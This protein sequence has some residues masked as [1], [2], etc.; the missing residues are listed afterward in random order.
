MPGIS[1]M[2][3][4]GGNAV[5]GNK[6]WAPDDTDNDG[7]T[8]GNMVNFEASN[9]TIK[10]QNMTV[11]ESEA[12]LINS[13][14]LWYQKHLLSS[15]SHGVAHTTKE[16]EENENDP[17][18]WLNPLESRLPYAPNLKIYCFYGVGKPTERAYFYRD[19]T[20][21]ESQ[22]PSI[23]IDTTVTS[24]NSIIDHGV[25]M[26]EG[27]GTVNLLS[28]GYMGAK[29][30]HMKRYNPAGIKVTVYEMPHEPD[31]FSPRG[32]PNTGDHV[33]ILGR[34]SLND[35]ILRI[36][37]GQGHLIENNFVSRIKEYADR[38]KIYEE[39]EDQ[40]LLSQIK[41]IVGQMDGTSSSS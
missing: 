2:L 10:R 6:T 23:A 16:I 36:A 8:F 4:K 26:S 28:L 3:P 14:E 39:E 7:F 33:D 12:F 32:G 34:S 38:V 25:V 18:K 17:R 31:R 11:E 30:W 19:E 1:S 29:G 20:T 27:D 41:G 21:D 22:R 15:Y 35:L 37:G 24:D 5:W 9:F 40:G 13:S